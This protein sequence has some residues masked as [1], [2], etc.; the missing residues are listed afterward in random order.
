MAPDRQ[1]AMGAFVLGGFVLG[2]GAIV[3]FGNFRL[4]NP[5]DVRRG[6]VPGLDQRPVR[7]RAGDVSR[8]AGGAV[9]SIGIE[10]IRRPRLPISL[11]PSAGART[12]AVRT[13]T[14]PDQI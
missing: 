13:T 12:R 9:D 10:F 1:T 4:F 14:T 8:R 5:D 7:W 11:S 3:L 2:L 6:G